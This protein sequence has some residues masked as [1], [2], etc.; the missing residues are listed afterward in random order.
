MTS[1]STQS[2]CRSCGSSKL[3]LGVDLGSLPLANG[4]LSAAEAN[5]LHADPRYPLR[6]FYCESCGLI[7]LIDIVNKEEMFGDYSFLTAASETSTAHFEDYAAEITNRFRLKSKD[8]VIDIGSNDGTLLKAF[9][10]RG[11]RVVGIEPATN[12]ATRTQAQGIPTLNEYFGPK[13]VTSIGAKSASVVTAN[14]VVSHVNELE[15][16]LKCVE[17]VLSLNGLFAFEVPWVVDVIRNRTFDIIYHEHLSYFGF[18]PLAKML[19]KQGLELIDLKHFSNIHGGTLRGIAAHLGT[20]PVESQA[21]NSAFDSESMEAT[22]ESLEKFDKETVRI[23]DEL[24]AMLKGLKNRGKSIVGYGA[25]AKATILLNYCGIDRSILE[26]VTDTTPLKQGKFIPGVR[27]PIVKPE[28]M[29]ILKP[30]FALLLA[31]NYKDEILRKEERY[32]R[33]GGKFILPFPEPQ[34]IN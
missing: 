34:I 30:D 5:S 25:P 8:L 24:L 27:V 20:F 2:E 11:T 13:T 22:S 3:R 23:K 21:L 18:R 12:L 29:A 33:S 32:L 16:F 9:Q 15:D 19:R 1:V 28:E 14:N 4:F 10:K 6:L 31:W 17:D 26:F 7:Q